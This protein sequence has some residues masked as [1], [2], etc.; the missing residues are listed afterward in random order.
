M[1]HYDSFE[2][3]QPIKNVKTLEGE[4]T[5]RDFSLYLEENSIIYA[6]E[7][8]TPDPVSGASLNVLLSVASVY[9]CNVFSVSVFSEE[10]MVA[11]FIR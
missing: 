2:S 10:N 7:V 6:S 9:L 3:F 11:H 8:F 4:T 1:I 5:V